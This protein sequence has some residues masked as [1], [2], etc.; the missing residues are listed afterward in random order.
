MKGKWDQMGGLGEHCK[1]NTCG[2]GNLFISRMH[3][4]PLF[5]F[6][7]RM[8]VHVCARECVVADAHVCTGM[9]KLEADTRYFLWPS[10]LVFQAISH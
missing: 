10:T 3:Y 5:S 6:S 4:S 1:R 7:V 9:Q 8:H 2:G